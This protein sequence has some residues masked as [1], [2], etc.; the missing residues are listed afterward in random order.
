MHQFARRALAVFA[1]TAPLLTVTARAQDVSL[2]QYVNPF[3]G[4]QA[5]P[6]TLEAGNTTPAALVPF[7]MVQLGP[8]TTTSSGGYRYNQSTMLDF[9]MTRY[10]GRAFASWLDVGLM[11][12]VGFTS[13]SASPGTSWSSYAQAFT[14]GGTAE[15]ARP[16]FYHVHL[17]TKNIDVDLTATARTGFMKMTFP[18]VTNSNVLIKASPSANGTGAIV[19]AGT[20]I[21]LDAAN[22][23]AT[24]SVE[25]NGSVHYR[26]FFALKFDR[27]WTGGGVWNGGTV[28]GNGTASGTGTAT[29]AWVNFDT[30][31]NRVVQVKIGIS[32]VSVANAKDNLARENDPNTFAAPAD[33][34]TVSNNATAAWNARLNQ[35]QVT[36]GTTNRNTIFY[37]ALYHSF[38]HPNLFSDGNG[39]YLGF[40]GAVHT[41][42]AGHVAQYHNIPGWDQSR[43]HAAFLAVMAPQEAAD[44]ADSLAND[45][46]QDAAPAC[47]PRWQQAAND[48]RGMVGDGGSIIASTIR[49]YG[50]T[51]YDGFALLDAM[52]NGATN[53]NA[54]SHGHTCRE[55]LSSYLANGYVNTSTGGGSGSITLE[56]AHTDFAVAQFADSLGDTAKRDV[57]LAHA[58]NWKTLW[59]ADAAAPA[60]FSYTGYLVPRT[61]AGAFDS[62]WDAKASNPGGVS[63]WS[64]G[65]G[66]QYLWMVEH[67][68]GGLIKLLGGNAT[69]VTRLQDHFGRPT[70]SNAKT[71]VNALIG[72]TMNAYLGNEPEELAPH[73]Y[74]WAA[75]PNKGAEVFR[76]MLINW[77]TN[78]PTGNP[79][80]DDGGSMGSWVVMASLGLNHAIPGVPGFVVGSPW[81]TQAKVRLPGGSVLQIDAPNA[82]DTNIYVQGLTWNGVAYDS[83]WV[84]WDLVKNGG[85]FNFNL[86]TSTAST[87]GTDPA[88]APP[89]FGDA[90]GTLQYETESLAVAGTSGDV[91]R[92][93]SDSSYS[94]GS[95]TILEGNAAADFVSYTV[96]VP[97]ARNYDVRVRI[98]QGTNRGIWQ[99]ASD[100]V[101][102]G[103]TVDGYASAS[104]FPEVD[105][106]TVSFTTA[107]NKTFRFTVTGKNAS[108][109]SFW[110]AL[111]YIKLVPVN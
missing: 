94:G 62:A 81:F 73:M 95:G 35:I 5:A 93:A 43:T 105:L 15:V 47:L 4:T 2:T 60:G 12:F 96:N 92:V 31:T 55:G 19:A 42:N 63:W 111:D 39:Q 28:T 71:E 21:T 101:N 102:H 23:M 14:H 76:R 54:K 89:S 70:D 77:Y 18:A 53:V 30:S 68:R 103:A 33:F 85:T 108:S 109:T 10:S 36:G 69:A 83:P 41:V 99:F 57:L 11:P 51:N 110:I 34:T 6:N 44:V 66:S 98:K 27:A 1:L 67:D 107:G 64:E 74:A 88:K 26:L 24:G 104:A 3:I 87:W 8:D 9:S 49:A 72:N 84:P 22:R 25:N 38:I 48:S 7:G 32:F 58:K 45:A 46:K 78:A 29:G 80:N 79:A 52:Y 40:D 75:A 82:S 91:H 90:A 16:G 106:G 65:N 50:I 97:T 61:S 37:T 17:D 56:Y 86:S 100:G 20:S 59:K 13:S